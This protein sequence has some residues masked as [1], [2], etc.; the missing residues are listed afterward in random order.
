M[1][2]FW[3]R[4][5]NG[6]AGKQNVTWTAFIFSFSR[7]LVKNLKPLCGCV[8]HRIYWGSGDRDK[9]LLA[10]HSRR[11]TFIYHVETEGCHLRKADETFVKS[12]L[13]SLLLVNGCSSQMTVYDIKKWIK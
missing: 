9:T 11:K 7:Y 2:V 6:F 5:L 12:R 8:R 3:A 13:L 1:T 4:D 10:P